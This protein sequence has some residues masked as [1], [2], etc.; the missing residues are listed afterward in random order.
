[1][2]RTDTEPRQTLTVCGDKPPQICRGAVCRSWAELS[3]QMCECACLLRHILHIGA[4]AHVFRST[5]GYRYRCASYMAATVWASHF[6][7]KETA[8][9]YTS[10]CHRDQLNSE[11]HIQAI[12]SFCSL[13]Y[14]WS[15]V[16][17]KGNSP[18]T[19]T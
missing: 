5:V 16:S 4:L 13:S 12:H 11:S 3:H 19:A 1:M 17:P 7:S 8:V 14:D 15:T 10:S 6:L 18:P 2:D 9:S